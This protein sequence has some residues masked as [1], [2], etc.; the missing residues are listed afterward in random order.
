VPN[1]QLAQLVREHFEMK[2]AGIIRALDLKRP[3]YRR[4]AAYGHF[5]RTPEDG[6][7]TWEKD[8]RADA[9]RRALGAASRPQPRAAAVRAVL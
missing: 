5:G 6:Y 8:D 9:L 7:F 3:I 2:P 1:E 4:T